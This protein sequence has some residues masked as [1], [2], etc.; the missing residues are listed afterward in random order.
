MSELLHDAPVE[1][2]TVGPDFVVV[3]HGTQVHRYDELERQVRPTSSTA[4]RSR[5]LADPG[6]ERLCTIATVNDVHFGE[7]VCGLVEG[8]GRHR[9]G[10]LGGAGR[11]AV[12]GHDEH[13][14]P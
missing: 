2:T 14:A 1:A 8:H 10:A 6:G 7:T 11:D 3:H 13:A 4:S 5:T 9:T 12:P